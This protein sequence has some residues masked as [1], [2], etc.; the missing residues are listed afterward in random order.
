MPFGKRTFIHGSMRVMRCI[1]FLTAPRWPFDVNCQEARMNNLRKETDSLGEVDVA[2]GQALGRADA[3][4]ARAFQHRQGPDAARDDRRLRDPEEGGGERQSRRRPSRRQGPQADRAGLRR[5]PRRPASRH[6]PA[7]RLDDRQR[8]AVQ[9]ERERGDLEPMLPA[10]RHAARQQAPGSPE[11]PRQ[12]VA[13]VER[14]LSLGHVHRGRDERR[15][16]ASSRR[17][18]RCTT[19]SRPRRASGT[20]SSR[21][22]EPT[23]RTRRR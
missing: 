16:S 4:L 20:T 14:Q 18:R 3:A 10:R 5:D 9:H 17:S 23:C 21:S 15:R 8:H 11:R 2:G 19:R 12:Y 13:I 6:V 1:H 7:A 22:A